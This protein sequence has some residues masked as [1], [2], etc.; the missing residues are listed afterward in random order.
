VL[1]IEI[2]DK[3]SNYIINLSNKCN[4]PNEL[5]NAV[6]EPIWVYVDSVV[7]ASLPID[8]VNNI[9]DNLVE[10]DVETGLVNITLSEL[11]TKKV[12]FIKDATTNQISLVNKLRAKVTSNCCYAIVVQ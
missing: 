8:I 2:Y 3:D 1:E 10:I 5:Y 11:L 7:Y 6:K 12:V 4:L 9:E